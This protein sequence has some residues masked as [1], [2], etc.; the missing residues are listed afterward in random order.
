M[1]PRTHLTLRMLPAP[2]SR[3]QIFLLGAAIVEQLADALN[4][5]GPDRVEIGLI[6]PFAIGRHTHRHYGKYRSRDHSSAIALH[7]IFTTVCDTWGVTGLQRSLR[8][9]EVRA[10]RTKAR[11]CTVYYN[12]TELTCDIRTNVGAVCYITTTRQKY[13]Y[14]GDS[15][16]RSITTVSS[17]VRLLAAATSAS[18]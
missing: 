8:P 1:W 15:S 2:T 7:H 5:L 17:S 14:T 3:S 11:W 4:F 9:L 6:A 10:S 16:I 13:R 18:C 12:N